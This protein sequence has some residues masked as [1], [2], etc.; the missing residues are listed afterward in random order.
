MWKNTR[1]WKIIFFFFIFDRSYGQDSNGTGTH[2][3][4]PLSSTEN[5]RWNNSEFGEGLDRIVCRVKFDAILSKYS[6]QCKWVYGL[7]FLFGLYVLLNIVKFPKKKSTF[8]S[9]EVVIWKSAC[10][11]CSILANNLI[12]I[13]WHSRCDSFSRDHREQILAWNHHKVIWHRRTVSRNW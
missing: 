13:R 5:S 3:G 1:F 8:R 2:F 12:W 10:W 7:F 4:R 11:I 9:L 6:E